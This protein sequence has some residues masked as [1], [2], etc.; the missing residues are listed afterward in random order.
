MKHFTLSQLFH[1]IAL[2][3][4]TF[5]LVR[6]EGCGTAFTRIGALSFSPD[7]K[8]LAVVKLN[9]R[10]A[11]VSLKG[12]AAD[13]L[14]T[15]SIVDV[16]KAIPT[17]VVDRAF[18]AGNQGPAF[19]IL[20]QCPDSLAFSA[21]GKRLFFLDFEATKIRVCDLSSKTTNTFFEFGPQAGNLQFA[22]SPDRAVVAQEDWGNGVVLLG[23]D[24]AKQIAK[25]PNITIFSPF[26][27]GISLSS[28]NHWLAIR[29]Q[30]KVNLYEVEAQLL[31]TGHLA[32]TGGFAFAPGTEQLAVANG[33]NITLS[34]LVTKNERNL[35][36]GQEINNVRFV[37]DG[38]VIVATEQE[39]I[40]L[41][42][43]TGDV[44][45]RLKHEQWVTAIA[46]SPDA[47]TV[48]IGDNRG[49]VVLWNV[50][51]GRSSRFRAPGRS[52]YPWTL[53]A[54]LL[55]V[56][57]SYYYYAWKRRRA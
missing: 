40:L 13:I 2:L 31:A 27:S 8:R 57:V 22:L 3:A 32:C 41:D 29:E 47:Q 48:A 26:R 21:D 11:N 35:A 50:K 1:G 4:L 12:Y 53:P 24:D 25:A 18:V 7:G 15:L 10:D 37:G 51:T 46:S 28:D 20:R 34:N 45:G 56:A 16:E 9:W 39:L 55:V 17:E 36:F 6:A 38:R 52:G 49:N 5:A 33:S 44:A 54:G 42:V 23:A 19:A 30:D 14:R 43:T